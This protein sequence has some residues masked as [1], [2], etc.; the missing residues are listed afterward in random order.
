MISSPKQ[1]QTQQRPLISLFRW[2]VLKGQRSQ[3]TSCSTVSW[4]EKFKH[5]S[6]KLIHDQRAFLTKILATSEDFELFTNTRQ[7]FLKKPPDFPA[8][9][10]HVHEGTLAYPIHTACIF[11]HYSKETSQ[12]TKLVS[13]FRSHVLARERAEISKNIKV[14]KLGACSSR[15]G[16]FQHRRFL[17]G[18]YQEVFAAL[19]CPVW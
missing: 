13:P 9:C 1:L 8:Y 2:F 17:I 10:Q 3:Q 11:E 5:H 14:Y 16:T 19:L 18:W 15:R 4:P 6:L 12:N 7:I